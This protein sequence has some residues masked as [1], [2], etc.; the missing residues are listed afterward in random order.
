MAQQAF[1]ESQV[2]QNSRGLDEAAQSRIEDILDQLTSGRAKTGW[3]AFLNRFSSLITRVAHQFED[4]S[5]RVS[6]CFLFVCGRLSDND[7]RRLLSFRRDGP[8][9]FTTWL[10]S[11]VA[12]LCI[13]W[14]RQQ[15]GRFRPIA[16]IA[17]LLEL[18]QCV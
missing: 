15:Q 2:N 14:R 12:N 1:T 9:R 10:T 16:A 11:V 17:G 7:F 18:E 13:D 4:D 3:T 8:A 6:D 5:E